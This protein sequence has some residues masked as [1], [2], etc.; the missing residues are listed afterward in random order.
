MKQSRK[1]VQP[2][3]RIGQV[4]EWKEN[5]VSIKL[6]KKGQYYIKK[7]GLNKLFNLGFWVE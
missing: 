6:N 2:F 1:N 5:K 7:I 3:K 4:V